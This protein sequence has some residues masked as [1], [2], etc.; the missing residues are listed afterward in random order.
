MARSSQYL[1]GGRGG[2]VLIGNQIGIGIQRH[3]GPFHTLIPTAAFAAALGFT[4][5]GKSR[6]HSLALRMTS[7]NHLSDVLADYISAGAFFKGH[8]ILLPIPEAATAIDL[9]AAA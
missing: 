3:G 9:T 2:R 8:L 4:G 7:L 5:I 1:T 6:S